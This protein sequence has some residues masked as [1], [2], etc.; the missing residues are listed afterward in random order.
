MPER[1]GLNG[2]WDV[3]FPIKLGPTADTKFNELDSWSSTADQ[4]VR[5][6][7]GTA[8]YQKEFKLPEE[9]LQ[10]DISL[11]LDLGSVRV[12]AEV[13]VNGK[14]LGILWKAPFKVNLDGC[15][16]VGKNQLE[17]QVT[18]L[19]PNR[20]IGDEQFPEDTKRRGPHVKQWPDWLL[21]QTDRPSN[22]I[23]FAGFKHWD[24]QSPLQ[25]SGLLGPVVIQPYQRAVVR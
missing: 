22:R 13:I 16:R 8:S 7:S 1:I 3:S 15:A 25:A 19:W 17:V 21:N 14:N 20:L 5:Y 23:S 11:E 2:P 4:R 9:L 10:S 18:N 6:F 24:K 12:I